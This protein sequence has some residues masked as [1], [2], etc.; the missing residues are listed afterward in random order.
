M[1]VFIGLD[2]SSPAKK[3]K[4]E[5][6]LEQELGLTKQHY[7]IDEASHEKAGSRLRIVY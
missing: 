3:G 2:P 1:R 6:L 5:S 4:R 7:G